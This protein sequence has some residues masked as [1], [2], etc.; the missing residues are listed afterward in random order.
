MVTRIRFAGVDNVVIDHPTLG[1]HHLY[2]EG[3]SE[4]LFTE[5]ETNYERVFNSPNPSPYVKDSINDYIVE[6]KSGGINPDRTG[7]K[8]AAVYRLDLAP[9][10]TRVLR[11]RLCDKPHADPF[12][13]FKAIFEQR[14]AEADAFYGELNDFAVSA[15]EKQIQREAFAGLLWSKQ[16]YEYSVRDWLIGDPAMPAAAGGTP[17]R[18]QLRLGTRPRRERALDAG[19]VGVSVVCGVGSCP[20]TASRFR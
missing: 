10:E 3:A 6:G 8:M 2:V 18:T 13:D 5:N 9:G 11:A 20:F 19:Y 7:T 4:L 17:A 1:E 16:F 12:G 15:D 14:I